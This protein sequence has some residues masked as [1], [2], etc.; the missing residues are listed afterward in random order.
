MTDELNK[1]PEAI[2][3]AKKTRRIVLENIILALVIKF[4]VLVIAPLG[5]VSINKFLIYEAIFADV[6]VSLIAIV[7]SLRIMRL[8]GRQSKIEQGELEEDEW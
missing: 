2:R 3:I 1:I 7:N 5:I 6:G 4:A 8:F